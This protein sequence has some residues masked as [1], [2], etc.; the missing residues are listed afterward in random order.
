MLG[1]AED[2]K[3]GHVTELEISERATG[4]RCTDEGPPA[5]YVPN[6]KLLKDALKDNKPSKKKKG[7]KGKKKKKK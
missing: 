1:K 4:K 3:I 6:V 7:K 5:V 2:G